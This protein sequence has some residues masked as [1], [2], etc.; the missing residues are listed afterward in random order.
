MADFS[1][2]LF[3]RF[4]QSITTE[5]A[6]H[7]GAFRSTGQ[8]VAI[9]APTPPANRHTNHCHISPASRLRPSN[10]PAYAPMPLVYAL[11]AGENQLRA[12]RDFANLRRWRS[13]PH[14][15]ITQSRRCRM[16]FNRPEPNFPATAD[17]ATES[18]CPYNTDSSNM[19]LDLD[20]SHRWKICGTGSFKDRE[21]RLVGELG[22][23]PGPMPTVCA[24]GPV[25]Q[26]TS[27]RRLATAPLP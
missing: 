18:N 4:G 19:S 7:S 10:V 27:G 2:P 14:F 15:L 12:Q 21:R 5:M 11:C 13:P 20:R 23:Y 1:R 8:N 22:R 25:A 26:A 3:L 17:M 16:C 9:H 6:I 24:G